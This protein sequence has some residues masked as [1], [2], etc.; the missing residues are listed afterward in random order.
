MNQPLESPEIRAFTACG[1]PLPDPAGFPSAR[2]AGEWI[3]FCTLA[4]WRAFLKDPEGFLNS[5]RPHP[6]EPS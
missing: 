4:C 1:S 2:F 5:T 3:Y 6:V